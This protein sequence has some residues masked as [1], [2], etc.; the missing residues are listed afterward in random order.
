MQKIAFMM[1]YWQNLRIDMQSM[2]KY[3]HNLDKMKSNDGVR[4]SESLKIRCLPPG[5]RNL[6]N[7][8]LECS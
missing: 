1:T 4:I 7:W 6:L 3:E 8:E 2:R 5:L